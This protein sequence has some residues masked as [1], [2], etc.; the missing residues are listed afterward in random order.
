M[1]ISEMGLNKEISI[2]SIANLTPAHVLNSDDTLN[3]IKT[4][5]STGHRRIPVVTK[6]ND[7]V[8][9]ITYM[10]ILDLLLRR[11]SLNTKVESFMTR[12]IVFSE[13]TDTV[14]HTLQKMKLSHRGGV[15]VTKK[16]KL[17]GLVS[18]RDFIQH[19][20]KYI[21]L[22]VS[23]IMSHR[24]FY[25]SPKTSILNTMKAMVNTH[26]RRLPIVDGKQ[27]VGIVTGLDILKYLQD[28]NFNQI[29]LNDNVEEIMATPVFHTLEYNDVSDAIRI[30]LDNKVGG[31]VVVN[32][33]NY[34]K[35]IITERD[36]IEIL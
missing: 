5:I 12:E 9:I 16:G 6:S 20:N 1:M 31:V 24:P 18:E 19:S 22:P 14:E 21:S 3:A 28:T 8:G 34:L 4:I 2:A 17:M 30:I 15:P 10:D 7:L 33:S 11:S 36:I 32:E 27:V 23:E 13:H 29:Y 35:G 26:Y 25:V